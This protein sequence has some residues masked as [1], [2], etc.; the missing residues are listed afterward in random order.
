MSRGV[1][2]VILIGNLGA[3]PDVRTT[4]SG[5]VV[6]NLRLA[7]AERKKVQG[8]WEDHTE[9]HR[10]TVF[11]S[12]AEFAGRYL[13]KGSKIYVEGR[14]QTRKWQDKDGNDRWT[15]EIVCHRLDALD[16]PS[17][18]SGNQ[19][20]NPSGGNQGGSQNSNSQPSGNAGSAGNSQSP[21]PDEEIPF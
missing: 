11:G 7:T 15:T 19:S 5:V 14:L 12:P 2:K 6:G 20:E 17:D 3:D 9:W 10:L 16:K 13:E 4:A 1:N 21:G 18:R 8:E